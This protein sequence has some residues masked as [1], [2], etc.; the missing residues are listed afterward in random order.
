[1]ITETAWLKQKKKPV[2]HRDGTV[3][4]ETAWLKQKKKPVEHRDGTVT[5]ET[6]WLKQKRERKRNRLPSR[7][8]AVVMLTYV[9]FDGCTMY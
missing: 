4:T 6:A 7:A 9:E 8:G 2:D 1:V 3:I 5:T